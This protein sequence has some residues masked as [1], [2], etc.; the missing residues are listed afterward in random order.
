[1]NDRLASLIDRRRTL[2]EELR[3]RPSG[4]EWCAR[5]TAIIDET[6][7]L[8]YRHVQDRFAG[9]GQVAI[10]ATGGFGRS[11]LCPF[12]DV[13]LTV[14]P[15]EETDP[16]LD[17]GV[18]ALFHGIDETIAR[19]LGLSVG[20]AYRLIG[21]A[22]GLDAKTRTGL[23]DARLVIGSR[24]T[25]DRLVDALWETL[26]VGEFLIAKLDERA[27]SMAKTNDTPLAVE[28][29]LKEGAGGLRCFH[30]ANWIGMAVG[31]R[32][33]RTSSD[34]ERVLTARNLLHAF[35][36]K[37]TERL[38]RSRQGEIAEGLGL[39]LDRWMASI[40]LSMCELHRRFLRARER[41]LEARFTL[42]PQVYALR[43]EA[44]IDGEV[45]GGDAAMG[46]AVA[47]KLGI[48]VAD[49]QATIAPKVQGPLAAAAIATGEAT[50]RNLDRCG[51]L[52]ALLPELGR[53][54]TLMPGDASHAYTVFEH[55]MRTVRM[56]DSLK[57]GS[58]FL[59]EIYSSLH[60]PAPLYLAALLHDVGKSDRLDEHSVTG[61]RMANEIVRRWKLEPRFADLVVWLVRWHLLMARCIGIRD[62]HH[63]DTVREFAE[64]VQDADRLA[65]LALLT[66][67]DVNAV[68]PGTWTAVQETYLRDLYGQTL[69]QLE[70]E[71]ASMPDTAV[72][73]RRLV[74]RLGG[75][76][77]EEEIRAFVES[78]PAHYLLSTSPEAVQDHYAYAQRA[79]QGNMSVVLDSRDDLDATDVIVACPDEAG[80][81]SQ[82]LGVFYALDLSLVGLR[83]CTTHEA[84]PVAI[85]VFT[86][87]FGGR[88]VP[89]ATAGVLVSTLESVLRKSLSVDDLIRSKGRDPE[90]KQEI[91]RYVFQE[92]S[93]GILEVRAPR[94]RGMAYRVSRLIAARGWNTVAARV[95][96]W[97]G[98]AAAAFYVL[99]P[100]G[101]PLHQ[102]DIEAAFGPTQEIGRLNSSGST[103]AEA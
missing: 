101:R 64:Q 12:S 60:D 69:H 93:P 47:T 50:L 56:L 99:G 68:A 35:S 27:A 57:R 74:R 79:K 58:G 6:L 29:D 36:G 23:L 66:W 94:G 40:S 32:A 2:I 65:M 53:C 85:D 26:P 73:R 7:A 10:V 80:L 87:M 4:L 24:R 62:V 81:L 97:A 61:A 21:D 37:R 3:S 71:T 86:V 19:G 30:S 25:Y 44:R 82:I 55:S 15:L 103:I 38:S 18:R 72:Y 42:A 63:P 8:V 46:I 70:S 39:D 28:P 34:F 91:A 11:E 31:A 14:V 92:G 84:S 76:V 45:D 96:Q 67:A 51:M 102:E 16:D 5:H 88:A 89:R 59:S 77:P 75:D 90:R 98:Q 49:I 83:A 41:L 54:R 13:D 1:M 22:P 78:L 52:D 95:G 9:L 20:Y 43:G 100:E 48:R 33:R 17:A